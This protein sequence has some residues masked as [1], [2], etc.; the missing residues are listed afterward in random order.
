VS[1]TCGPSSPGTVPTRTA[2][3]NIERGN[4]ARLAPIIPRWISTTNGS[5][6]RSVLGGLISE[7]ERAA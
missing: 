1:D 7:Y 2:G 5:R 6:R 4:F 3:A